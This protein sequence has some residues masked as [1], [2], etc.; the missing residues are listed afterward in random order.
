[1]GQEAVLGGALY[2]VALAQ[3][4]LGRT[5][6][7]RATA[8]DALEV[9]QAAGSVIS[10]ML[11]QSVMGSLELAAGDA[12]AASQSLRPLL[13]WAEVVGVREPGVIRFVPD[14]AEA[15][16]AT[17]ALDAADAA[18]RPFERDAERLQRPTSRLAAARARAIHTASSGDVSAGVLSLER[19]L[20]RDRAQAQPLE[21][22]RALFALGGLLRRTRRRRAAIETL[23]S[24]L[25]AFERLGA[26]EWAE[27]ASALVGSG[28]NEHSTNGEPSLTPA[29]QRVASLVAHGHTNREVADQLFVSVRAVEV[30]LTSIYRKLGIASRTQLA[31]KLAAAAT[32][33][34]GE[35]TARGGT[36]EPGATPDRPES[37]A[38]LPSPEPTR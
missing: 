10:M 1:M 21:L 4:H 15:M 20:E 7:A 33:E 30:H 11:A 34:S 17:G 18:L 31:A 29:E 37:G 19:A 27:R 26:S 24:A 6:D 28:S 2:T 3:A 25:A 13:A 5:S 35:L 9:A 16:V 32:L 12:A 22:A 23:G 38:T 14:A 36:P 8:T